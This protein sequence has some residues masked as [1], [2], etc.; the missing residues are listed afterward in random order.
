M[1][2]LFYKK[3]QQ[4]NLIGFK[5]VIKKLF[6]IV[7]KTL[8]SGTVNN[9][10]KEKISLKN[11]VSKSYFLTLNYSARDIVLNTRTIEEVKMTSLQFLIKMISNVKFTIVYLAYF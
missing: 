2:Y 9:N 8:I 4:I 6:K 1:I 3:F 10:Q 7:Y 5:N 11:H